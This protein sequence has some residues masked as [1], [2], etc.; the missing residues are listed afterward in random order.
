[1]LFKE[2]LNPV[3]GW[4]AKSRM[5]NVRDKRSSGS[6]EALSTGRL[7]FV[8]VGSHLGVGVTKLFVVRSR[9][10][11]FRYERRVRAFVRGGRQ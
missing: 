10:V 8:S 11:E 1:M 2:G 4:D 9:G 7:C 3:I 5:I 6:R